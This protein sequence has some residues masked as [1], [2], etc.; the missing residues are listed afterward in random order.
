MFVTNW[1]LLYELLPPVFN[2]TEHEM[3]QNYFSSNIIIIGANGK[4][5]EYT[6]ERILAGVCSNLPV[7]YKRPIYRLWEIVTRL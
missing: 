2:N 5:M 1:N 7:C 3:Y 4:Y 6:I